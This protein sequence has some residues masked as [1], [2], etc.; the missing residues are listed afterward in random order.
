MR[1]QILKTLPRNSFRQVVFDLP[2]FKLARGNAARQEYEEA[3]S[4]AIQ[5]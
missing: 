3:G 2:L 5:K 1:Q 4:H